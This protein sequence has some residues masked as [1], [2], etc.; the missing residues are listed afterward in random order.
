MTKTAKILL[1]CVLLAALAALV[2][3]CIRFGAAPERAQS[4]DALQTAMQLSAAA[5]SAWRDGT[6]V[7]LALSD[8]AGGTVSVTA[9]GVYRVSGSLHEGQLKVACDGAVALLLDNVEISN[10]S[11]AAISV[12]ETAQTLIYL[13]EGSE[14]RLLS[15]GEQEITAAEGNAAVESASGAALNAKGTLFFAGSGALN[16]GGYRNNAVAA[17][18]QLLVL[19]GCLDISAVNNGLKSKEAV[20]IQDGAITVHCGNDGIKADD[21]AGGGDVTISGGEISIVSLGD[22][23]QAEGDLLV[24][25]GVITVSAGDTAQIGSNSSERPADFPGNMPGGMGG[26]SFDLGAKEPDAFP[27]DGETPPEKPEGAEQGGFP[28]FGGGEAPP[29]LP[30]NGAEARPDFERPQEPG[31]QDGE[32]TDRPERPSF[33]RPGGDRGD[34]ADRF[35]RDLESGAEDSASTKGLKSGGDLTVSG[36]S[37]TV[38]SLDD[39]IHANGSITVSG[40]TFLLYTGDDGLHADDSLTVSGG[41]ITV[42]Q[43][44]EGLEAN[45]IMISGGTVSVTASDD[46]MNA[47]GGTAMFGVSDGG[48]LPTLTVSGGTV[49][50]N[51][52][53]DGL[54]SNGNLIIEG[55]TVIVDGPTNGGNGALDAGTENGGSILCNGGTVLAIGASGMAESFGEDSKQCSFIHSYDTAMPAGTKIAISDENGEPIFE[56]ESVKSFSSVVF[57]SP[58]LVLGKAYTV[59]VGEQTEAVTMERMANGASSGF[60]MPGGFGGRGKGR[61]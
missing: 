4:G 15:G 27:Q 55:G 6:A 16:V 52:E 57:S 31:E 5:E 38:T 43:S 2:F 35:D 28:G 47:N 49:Y 18:G 44:Y 24:A 46:G 17:A 12:S 20:A 60:G 21:G 37:L 1:V 30:E 34:L 53:G 3:C 40:G 36:G 11:D 50:V 41:D 9:P 7:P 59:T 54:D 56:Y 23:V 10:S 19:G 58:A 51:A 29:E 48:T 26:F 14:S 61:K 32:K 25:D 13:P 39:A 33:G 45:H 22:G 8:A 42:S